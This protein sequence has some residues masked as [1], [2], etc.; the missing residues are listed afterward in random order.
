[1]SK[2]KNI[3][4]QFLYGS[5]VL[6]LITLP[7]PSYSINSQSIIFCVLCWLFFNSFPEKVR[8]IKSNLFSFFLLSSLFW[9]SLLGLL[10][11]QDF[12]VGFKNVQ[13][14]LP[15]LVFPLVFSSISITK[16][17]KLKLLEYFSYGVIIASLFAL[18][19]AFYFK[20]SNLGDFFYYEQFAL[21]LDRHT[22]YF[23]LFTVI[24]IGYFLNYFLQRTWQQSIKQILAI[25]FLLGILYL[26]S[27]RISIVGLVFCGFIVLIGNSRGM[28]N[29]QKTAMSIAFLVVILGYFT[30][31]FQNRFNSK[32]PEG[33]TISDLDTRTI[34]W[35]SVLEIIAENNLIFGAGTG[36]GHLRLYEK[37]LKNGFET[38]YLYH[39]NAHNQFL[40]TTLYQGFIGLGLLMTLFFVLLWKSYL[41][42]NYL[43]M[44]IISVFAVFMLTESILVRQSGI[45]I[46]AFVISMIAFSKPTRN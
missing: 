44:A 40:E 28:N 14:M 20:F 16:E 29:L 39:Y 12:T 30:P 8:N 19:K 46:F 4:E 33:I 41:D 35:K 10:Y 3:R 23:A 31:N 38:G 32:T 17:T 37:Y 2:L 21:L 25:F 34:H 9:L 13:K 42:K 5:L 6:V 1:M 7:L 22:T 15:F 18:T 45:V 11:T 43:E 27:V 36:D 26:L 24:A